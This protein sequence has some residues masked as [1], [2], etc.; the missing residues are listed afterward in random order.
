MGLPPGVEVLLPGDRLIDG[1]DVGELEGE[2]PEPF[3][4]EGA[5]VHRQVST[6]AHLDVED[7]ALDVG[8]WPFSSQ[9]SVDTRATVADDHGWGRDPFEQCPPRGGGF[10]AT[11]L[12]GEDLLLVGDGDQEAPAADVDPVDEDL[13]VMPFDRAER[14]FK[15]PAPRR[16]VAEGAACA[17]VEFRLGVFACQPP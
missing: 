9:G 14:G 16:P 15:V 10:L 5:G 17:A 4:G 8:A 1:T 3:T 11:P 2:F 6:D 7:A 13:V 12:P